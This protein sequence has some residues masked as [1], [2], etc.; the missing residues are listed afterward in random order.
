LA[1]KV[2]RHR[3]GGPTILYAPTWEGYFEDS[4]HSS[5]EAMGTEIV[6]IALERFPEA[7]ILFKPHPLTG[8]R[9]KPWI[10][11]VEEIHHVLHRA[12]GGHVSGLDHPDTHLYTW[13]D[14]ADL[15]I[16]DVSSVVTDFLMWDRPLVV[17]NPRGLPIEEFHRR[18]P[19]TVAGH[20]IDRGARSLATTLRSALEHDPLRR[21]RTEAREHFIGP[22]DR[23]PLD[24]FDR[25]LDTHF[26]ANSA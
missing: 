11:I 25:A 8:H 17:A 2:A 23:D 24:L 15:L 21:K 5:I 20:T 22:V 13:F 6:R 12:Q 3:P 10:E 19:T 7:R 9:L 4:N 18:F 14:L 16:A 1:E 26:P